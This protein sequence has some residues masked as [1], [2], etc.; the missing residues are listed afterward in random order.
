MDDSREEYV[1]QNREKAKVRQ[2]ILI[3]VSIVFFFGSAVMAAIPAIQE[4]A[5]QDNASVVEGEE[6]ILKQQ[7]QGFELVL[8]REPN[9]QVA[10]EGLVKVRVALKDVRGAI[11]PLE[12]LVEL[13]PQRED[14]KRGLNDLKKQVEK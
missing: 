2:K 1:V 4:I 6:S 3:L 10:L 8:Q 14:Y 11:E 7:E 12:K 13:N 5:Q 9:N